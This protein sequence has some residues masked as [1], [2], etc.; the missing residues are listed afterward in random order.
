M[1]YGNTPLNIFTQQTSPYFRAPHIYIAIGSR[2]IPDRK[3]LTDAQLME[4]K[5]DPVSIKA[6]QNH[7]L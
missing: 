6:S 2:F 4:L 7:S 1:T 5:V 3:I